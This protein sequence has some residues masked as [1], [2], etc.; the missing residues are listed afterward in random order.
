[1]LTAKAA[2]LER[3]AERF[4]AERADLVRAV[5]FMRSRAQRAVRSCAH[6]WN[7]AIALLDLRAKHMRARVRNILYKNDIADALDCDAKCLQ[8]CAAVLK[9]GRASE[10]VCASAERLL[11]RREPALVPVWTACAP[12]ACTAMSPTGVITAP[13]QHVVFADARIFTFSCSSG[14]FN[15]HEYVCTVLCLDATGAVVPN[16]DLADIHIAID[17]LQDNEYHLSGLEGCFDLTLCLPQANLVLDGAF[18]RPR[19]LCVT[20]IVYLFGA[21]FCTQVVNTSRVWQQ[22]HDTPVE[23]LNCIAPQNEAAKRARLARKRR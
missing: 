23:L 3:R 8:A 12:C 10:L 4:E 17:G 21:R 13:P 16:I 7:D 6:E 19:N 11:E 1:M 9:L 2:Q 22:L 20:C 5:V 14:R 15:V 18:G